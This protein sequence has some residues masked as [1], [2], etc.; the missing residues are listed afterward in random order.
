MLEVSDVCSGGEV[1]L[2][3]IVALQPYPKLLDH[4]MPLRCG[5][6]STTLSIAHRFDSFL[7]HA[8]LAIGY[9]RHKNRLTPWRNRYSPASQYCV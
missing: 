1:L 3:R 9:P 8:V 6:W 5:R 7:G 2:V 4:P